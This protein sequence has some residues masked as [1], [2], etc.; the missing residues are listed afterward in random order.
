M[1]RFSFLI[2]LV[3]CSFHMSAQNFHFF[4]NANT[5][6]AN[7]HLIG[8]GY[9][10]WW[11][12]DSGETAHVDHL[13]GLRYEVGFSDFFGLSAG[14]QRLLDSEINAVAL[15]PKISFGS[16]AFIPITN[17]YFDGSDSEF[18]W[19]PTLCGDIGVTDLFWITLGVDYKISPNDFLDEGF[20]FYIM[21]G[22]KSDSFSA[23]LGFHYSQFEGVNSNGLGIELS[24]LFGSGEERLEIPIIFSKEPKKF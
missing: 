22:F 7:N 20:G 4:Q 10:N 16:F 8:L 6:G 5:L 21:P 23:R 11:L 12:S 15:A 18:V 19:S 24:Y 14:Y 2:C 1:K 9:N 3:F 17:L 13:V